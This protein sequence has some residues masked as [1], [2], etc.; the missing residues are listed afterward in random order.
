MN[1]GQ[2]KTATLVPKR[3]LLVID[4]EQMQDRRLQVVQVHRILDNVVPERIRR[5]VAQSRLYAAAGH[6]KRETSRMVVATKIVTTE[7]PLAIIRASEFA[8]PNHQRI[9]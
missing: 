4:T 5:A 7:F 1:I 6:P 3:Q 2:T 8:A 9:V